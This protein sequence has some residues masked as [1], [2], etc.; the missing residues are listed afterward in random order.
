MRADVWGPTCC[1]FDII[2]T[3]RRLSTVKEGDWILY[4]E[5]GAYSLCLS[6]NFN[7]FSPPKVLYLTSAENWQ[8]VSRNLQR[9]RSEGA[10]VPEKI[11]S[12]I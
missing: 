4:P 1:S 12:K 6:T 3:D 10:D 8:N 7:G 11:L 2:E 5:C 9:V